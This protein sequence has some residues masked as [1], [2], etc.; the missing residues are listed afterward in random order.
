MRYTENDADMD[1]QDDRL[2]DG[3]GS[4]ECWSASSAALLEDEGG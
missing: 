1:P 3:F 4:R 2:T